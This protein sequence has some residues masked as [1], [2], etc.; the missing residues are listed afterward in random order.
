[1]KLK[2]LSEEELVEDEGIE[3]DAES[4]MAIFVPALEAQAKE[5]VRQIVELLE[6]SKE[7]G[8]EDEDGRPT[9]AI[10]LKPK[11]WQELK[12]LAEVKK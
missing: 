5:T 12:A 1:M 3:I 8:F 7:I 10:F 2:I 6:N 4:Y 11:E 9:I